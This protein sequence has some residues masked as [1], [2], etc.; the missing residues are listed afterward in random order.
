MEEFFRDYWWLLFPI[1]AFVFGAWDR[2]LAY[3]RSRDHLDLLK[4]YAEQG[5]EPP[6]ELV[7]GVGGDMNGE[8][9]GGYGPGGPGG[10]YGPYG[11]GWGGPRYMRRMYRNYYRYGPYWQWRRV[12]VTGAVAA[13]F[14]WAAQWADWPGADG[15]FHIVAIIMTI[16]TIANLVFA[17]MAWNFRDK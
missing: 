15:A 14:W 3:K 8:A 6:P 1:G 5:K 9:P 13:G 16:I 17:L 7:R 11:Y 10:P 2:W 12:L 4:H